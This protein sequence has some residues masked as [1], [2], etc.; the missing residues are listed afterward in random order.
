MASRERNK[1]LS[2]SEKRRQMQER[3][4]KGAEARG[5]GVGSRADFTLPSRWTT[6]VKSYEHHD[7]LKYIS[8]GKTR[9]HNT[10]RLKETLAKRKMDLC[11]DKS[12]ESS[13]NELD[14]GDEFQPGPSRKLW[15]SECKKPVEVERQL[16]ICETSQ[17]TSFVDDVN[18]TSR[19]STLN[20]NGTF[21][22]IQFI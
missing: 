8:P 15:K 2:K 7:A 10:T 19:C 16:V 13:G 9:Y 18:G 17:I 4:R 12:S 1:K 5:V 14:E 20:C 22:N 21:A 3:G 11:L 6:E